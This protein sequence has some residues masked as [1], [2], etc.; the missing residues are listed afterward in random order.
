MPFAKKFIK[1]MNLP[2]EGDSVEGFK[3]ESV[4]VGHIGLRG[5]I[6]EYP[7]KIIVVGK[8][9]K[10]SVKKTFKKFLDEKKTIFSG[11]GNPYQCTGGKMEIEN[12][13]DSRY[14]IKARGV[15]VRVFLKVEFEKF[16][17]YLRKTMVFDE[18]KETFS[19]EQIINK[20]LKEYQKI[21][22]K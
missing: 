21:T 11:Y 20:Y 14:V 7:F 2:N 18:K 19:N 13:G 3:I 12:L 8:G 16:I 1:C 4:K 10:I 9:G 5:G 15:C 6:Y 17:Q 22:S